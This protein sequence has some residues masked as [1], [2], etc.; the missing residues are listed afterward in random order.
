MDS[1]LI[2]ALSILVILILIH[3]VFVTKQNVIDDVEPK[4]EIKPVDIVILDD[5][6]EIETKNDRKIDDAQADKKMLMDEY[7]AITGNC[8]PQGYQVPT[9][10]V[11]DYYLFDFNTRSLLDGQ[12]GRHLYAPKEFANYC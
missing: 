9:G 7:K 4:Q 5:E 10:V 3:K 6:P 8:I 1:L 12:Y 11:D 2:I